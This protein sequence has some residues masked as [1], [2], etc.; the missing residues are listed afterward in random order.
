MNFLAFLFSVLRILLWIAALVCLAAACFSDGPYVLPLRNVAWLVSLVLAAIGLALTFLVWRGAAL[1][2][3]SGRLLVLIWIAVPVAAVAVMIQGKLRMQ[4]ILQTQAS[5]AQHLGKH[6]VVGYWNVRE[7]RE[8]ARKGLIGGIFVTRRNAAK[9]AD[10]LRLE[11]AELQAIRRSAGLPPLIVTA[12]QEGGIVSQ[13][14]PPLSPVP[15][16]SEFAALPREV[17]IRDVKA[18]GERLGLELASIGINLNFAPVADLRSGRGVAMFDFYSQIARRAISDDPDV[19]TDV[20]TAFIQGMAAQGVQATLKHFPGLGRVSEDTHHVIARIGADASTLG[21]TD[22]KPFREIAARTNAAVMAGHVIVDGV[23]PDWPASQSKA[24]IDGVL[25]KGWR[26]EGL[27]VT[28]DLNMGAVFH[29]DLCAGVAA[30]LNA[31]VD[32]LLVSYDGRQYYRIMQCVLAAHAQGKL[33]GAMLTKSAERLKR[34]FG[35][36]AA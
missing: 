14:S 4:A 17:R 3:W 23:D 24:L 16:L 34:F 6:F 12:D 32:L 33:D 18:H 2:L 7:V 30:S 31:G 21:D 5:T 11:I 19:V 10:A 36:P 22:W 26:F 8:L 29:R 25:R 20:A 13:L 27:V 35:K 1:R 15:A 28:D 9:G